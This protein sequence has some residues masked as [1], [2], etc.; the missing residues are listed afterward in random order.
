MEEEETSGIHPTARRSQLVRESPDFNYKKCKENA[1][2]LKRKE[3]P[4]RATCRYSLKGLCQGREKP[5][6]KGS[7][8]VVPSL[9]NMQRGSVHRQEVDWRLPEAGGRGQWEQPL[10]G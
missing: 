1:T 2:H 6:T 4:T 3:V 5:D 9:G 8:S 10:N 7:Y